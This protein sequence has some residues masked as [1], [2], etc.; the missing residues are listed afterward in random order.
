MNYEYVSHAFNG[1]EVRESAGL[2]K[3]NADSGI[4]FAYG[5]EAGEDEVLRYYNGTLTAEEQEKFSAYFTEEEAQQDIE[6]DV[7]GKKIT[8][9]PA[10]DDECFTYM[11]GYYDLCEE[12]VT[13]NPEREF[14]FRAYFNDDAAGVSSETLSTENMSLKSSASS[15]KINPFEL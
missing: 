13:A 7:E 14:I 10:I 15:M 6:W 4:E 2:G 8:A 11:G 12:I 3:G 5:L 1:S 9:F